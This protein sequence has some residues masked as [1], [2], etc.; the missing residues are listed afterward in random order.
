MV[1]PPVCPRRARLLPLVLSLLIA[2]GVSACQRVPFAFAP[3]VQQGNFITTDMIAQLEPGLGQR[4]V[5][6]ILGSPMLRHG[7][8]D[9]RWDYV[10]ATS[11]GGGGPYE[12]LTL[13]FDESGRLR[14]L[15]GTLVPEVWQN[16]QR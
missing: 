3:E 7:R 13:V 12:R 4:D 1:R 2:L 9:R 15:E 5:L 11:R 16:A 6:F 8:E 10:H 14:A